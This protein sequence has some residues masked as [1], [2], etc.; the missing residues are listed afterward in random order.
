MIKNDKKARFYLK[1]I[2]QNI[3]FLH[4]FMTSPYFFG[5]LQ[6]TNLFQIVLITLTVLHN[7]RIS[8]AN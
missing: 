6:W 4:F 5:Y 3:F 1:N 7:G 8:K 2:I